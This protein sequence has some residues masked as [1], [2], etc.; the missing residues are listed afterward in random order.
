MALEALTGASVFIDDL[1]NTNP[2]SGDPK[3]EGDDHI[4][5]IKNVLINT[6]A[7]ITGAITATQAELNILDGVTSTTAELNILDGATVV[8]AELNKL[9]GYTGDIPELGTAQEWTGQ[10]N[11]NAAVLADGATINWNLNTEQVASVTLAGNRTIAAPTNQ[12]DGSTYILHIIQDATGGRTLTW[13]SVFKWAGG[14]TPVLSSAA[15]AHDI[16]SCVSDGTDMFCNILKD[17]S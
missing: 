1:V 12:V 11:F 16:I 14:V 13:N 3:S 6:F 2:V 7:N 9:A 15:S 8:V 5:G 4:R 10:Q 17:Y